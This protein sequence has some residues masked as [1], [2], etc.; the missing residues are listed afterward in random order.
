MAT[1]EVATSGLRGTRCSVR[2]RPAARTHSWPPASGYPVCDRVTPGLL[3][4]LWLRDGQ[5]LVSARRPRSAVGPARN[6]QAGQRQPEA[7]RS[8]SRVPTTPALA[9]GS[10]GSGDTVFSSNLGGLF[11]FRGAQP[12]RSRRVV[13]PDHFIAKA[14]HRTGPEAVVGGDTRVA[15]TQR[16]SR[17]TVKTGICAARAVPWRALLLALAAL[18]RRIAAVQLG[19]RGSGRPPRSWRYRTACWSDAHMRRRRGLVP[20]RWCRAAS[21]D[22]PRTRFPDVRLRTS[23]IRHCGLR[24][25]E[26][27]AIATR[28]TRGRIERWLSRLMAEAG[29]KAGIG[30]A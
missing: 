25:A 29:D 23:A 7:S 4:H 12:P 30:R 8:Q 9:Q 20:P 3:P 10:R 18:F 11:P 1:L 6:P 27:H 26:C 28:V 17:C 13:L 2:R 21:K 16:P 24:L 5:T 22:A 14:F 19:W 15:S